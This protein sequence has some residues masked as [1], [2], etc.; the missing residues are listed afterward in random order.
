MARHRAR[1]RRLRWITVTALAFA[2]IAIAATAVALLRDPGPPPQTESAEPAEPEVVNVCTT[3]RIVAATSFE[4]VLAQLAPPLANGSDCVRLDVEVADGQAAEEL[5]S[6]TRADVWIPD[7]ASWA[8]VARTAEL[9]AEAAAAGTIVATSPIF[10]VTDQATAGRL[11]DAGG[12]W[13]DL[14]GLLT[15]DTGTRLVV[16]DPAGSGDGLVGV[17]AVGEAVWLD[18]GMD[19]SAEALMT[20]FPSTLTV[21]DH[22]LPAQQG[23]VGLVAEYA[24]NILLAD[25]DESAATIR[26]GSVLAGTDYSAML[27]YSWFPTVTGTSDEQ[28]R[29]AMDRLL[30]VLTG[31]DAA[32]VL[33]EAGLRGADGRPFDRSG[34]AFPAVDAPAFDVLGTHKVD[35]VFATWYTGERTSDV[36]VVIDV[37]GSMA[38]PAPGSDAPLIDLVREGVLEL[39][40]LLPDESQ[41]ALWQFGAQLDP[42]RDYVELLPR[43]PLD[44]EHR[45][46]LHDS[47]TEMVTTETGTGL[48]DTTLAAY[49][50]A[51]D[52]YRD[53]V[54]S[55]VIVFTDGRNEDRPGTISIEQLTAELVEA[56][57]PDRPV[58][59]TII[60]FGEDTDAELLESALEDTGVYVAK[61]GN[62]DEVHAVFIHQAAGGRH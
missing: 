60:T 17:G 7:D 41:L 16:R 50:N 23:D 19:A 12:G 35:H 38:A 5:V 61:I 39:A 25:E 31:E 4:P 15:A 44:A 37:S 11:N 30:E 54:P 28:T 46:A 22:A 58:Q 43:A 32:A 2:G 40:D 56:T 20:A 26:S 8:G 13:L 59:L 27:R 9:D 45:G 52:S 42:P 36:L 18:A 24:L 21:T 51:R 48:Y 57:D 6:E 53:G 14:A 55:H 1:R 10:M 49:L 62:A 33:A 47:A 29:V 34:N 3:L